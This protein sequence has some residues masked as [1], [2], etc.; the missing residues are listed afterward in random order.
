MGL[1]YNKTVFLLQKM[2]PLD[3]NNL[4]GLEKPFYEPQI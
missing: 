1:W 4:H 3:H 2:V